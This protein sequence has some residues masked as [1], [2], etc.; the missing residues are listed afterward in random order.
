MSSNMNIRQEIRR[1]LDH[2]MA[3]EGR[4][5]AY[6]DETPLL[7]AVPE[8]D[9][10]AVVAVLTAIEERFDVLIHDDEIDGA[11]FSTLGSLVAFVEH[12]LAE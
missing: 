6:A 1:I 12:K 5:L 3:L 11:A 8:L 10:M 9:S 4:A 7:G 2:A